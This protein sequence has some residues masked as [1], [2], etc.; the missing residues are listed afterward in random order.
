[1]AD[2]LK[3]LFK[4]WKLYARMDLNW[5]MQDLSGAAIIMAS[6]LIGALASLSGVLLLA[7]RFGGVGGLSADEVLFMLGFY[8]LSD[9]LGMVLFGNYN[10]LH[11]S[12]RI[13]RGQVDHMLIQP[14]PLWVQLLTEGFMPFTGGAGMLVGIVLTALAA[15]RLSLAWT[16]ARWGLFA[17]YI[18]VHLTLRLSLSALY[19]A[20]AFWRPVACEEISSMTVDLANQLGVFPLFGLPRWLSLILHTVL[21]VG[22]LAYLPALSLLDRLDGAAAIALPA[23]VATAIA[24]A[25]I[26]CFRKGLKHYEIYS[27]NRYKEMGFRN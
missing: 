10:V 23:A 1:M 2:N 5:L 15:S 21:P 14:R 18:V 22:L 9:G 25:A 20:M 19:G 24:A 4:L 27:C 11:I 3:D 17:F 16:A 13:G 6:D 8:R 7:M 26:V 12:R